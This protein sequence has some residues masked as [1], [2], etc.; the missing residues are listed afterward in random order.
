MNAV[1]PAPPPERDPQARTRATGL[2]VAILLLWP[3][4]VGPTGTGRKGTALAVAGRIFERAVP[5]WNSG[6]SCAHDV[7]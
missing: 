3:V 7:S 4:L 6:V 1:L 2:L 5:L